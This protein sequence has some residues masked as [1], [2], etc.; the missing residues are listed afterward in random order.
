MIKK[1]TIHLFFSFFIFVNGEHIALAQEISND[2]SRCETDLSY[3]TMEEALNEKADAIKLDIAMNKLT[4]IDPKIGELTNLECLDLSFNKISNL[5]N[6]IANLKKLRVLDLKGT[7]YLPS[8]PKIIQEL[9]NLQLL[10]LRNH[11]EWTKEKFE[12]AVTMLP[13]TIVLVDK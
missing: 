11:P 10:D 6:E 1:T 12:E 9:T 3:Y 5:P 8:L 13:N 4:S 2:T 7:R